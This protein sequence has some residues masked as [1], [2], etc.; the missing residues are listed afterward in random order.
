M[1]DIDAIHVC[2][3]HAE[4]MCPTEEEGV[5]RFSEVS[6]EV[7]AWEVIIFTCYEKKSFTKSRVLDEHKSFFFHGVT[8]VLKLPT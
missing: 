7:A 5:K 2:Y 3:P 8:N 6:V 1:T 4:Y